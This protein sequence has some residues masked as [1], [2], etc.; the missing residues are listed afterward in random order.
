MNALMG[1]DG[2]QAVALVDYESGMLLGE[3][4]AGGRAGN[5]ARRSWPNSADREPGRRGTRGSNQHRQ[6]VR[7]GW[8]E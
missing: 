8:I 1:I 6:G 2:A 5:V 4:G 3:A 7:R